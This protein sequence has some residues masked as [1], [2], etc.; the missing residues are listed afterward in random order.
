MLVTHLQMV[1]YSHAK[2]KNRNCSGDSH[3]H[4]QSY[5]PK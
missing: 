5:G 4:D 3:D 2:E 1:D